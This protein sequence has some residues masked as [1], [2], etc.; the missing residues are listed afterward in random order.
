MIPDM[1][2]ASVDADKK[3]KLHRTT[4]L[5]MVGLVVNQ[6]FILWAIVDGLNLVMKNDF[7]KMSINL[8]GQTLVGHGLEDV[9]LTDTVSSLWAGEMGI[10][11]NRI[12]GP[13]FSATENGLNSMFFTPAIFH[14]AIIH[15]TF[16][17]E[18]S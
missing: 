3:L 2:I 5:N 16:F 8:T 1:A 6:F 15:H 18:H 7:G 13:G 11:I 17:K 12:Y 14:L 9:I 4:I 10:L